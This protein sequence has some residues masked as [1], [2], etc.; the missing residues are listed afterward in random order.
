MLE[1]TD[2][3]KAVYCINNIIIAFDAQMLL[4][5]SIV[6]LQTC[7]LTIDTVIKSF[8]FQLS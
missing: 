2:F 8:R 1:L 4:T 3:H 7:N 6:K 5:D